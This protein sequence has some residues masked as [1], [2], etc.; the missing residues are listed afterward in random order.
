M[1]PVTWPD[2]TVIAAIATAV[3][4]VI[5][6]IVG[7][8]VTILKAIKDLK[9]TTSEKLDA[10]TLQVHEARVHAES[11]AIGTASNETKLAEIQTTA[12]KTAA[13]TDGQMSR[14]HTDL[15]RALAEKDVLQRMLSET[16]TL[17]A[18]ANASKSATVTTGT[19]HQAVTTGGR[20]EGDK[21]VAVTIIEKG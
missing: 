5:G 8:A 11:A 21:P 6:S 18:A 15:T 3:V 7:G 2:P 20:R 14:I 1:A 17:L 10:Q 12:E 16:T 13:Q 9:S 19:S 4:M